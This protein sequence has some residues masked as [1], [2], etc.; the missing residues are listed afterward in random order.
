MTWCNTKFSKTNWQRNLLQ[1]ERRIKSLKRGSLQCCPS[2]I[3]RKYCFVPEGSSWLAEV[4]AFSIFRSLSKT[5]VSSDEVS[6]RLTVSKTI[7]SQIR[8]MYNWPSCFKTV[9]PSSEPQWL[10]HKVRISNCNHEKNTVRNTW[11][12]KYHNELWKEQTINHSTAD[13][14]SVRKVWRFRLIY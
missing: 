4:E 10:M 6:E 2:E 8:N 9:I 12:A 13:L 5:F 11:L 1:W 14:A 7:V 3:H